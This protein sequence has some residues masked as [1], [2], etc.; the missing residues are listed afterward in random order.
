LIRIDLRGITPMR[1]TI[2]YLYLLVFGFIG[3][4]LSTNLDMKPDVPLRLVSLILM[5]IA[6]IGLI[7]KGIRYFRGRT[8][9]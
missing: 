5:L 6:I 7:R 1:M 9:V 8:T 3:L 2:V 4:G